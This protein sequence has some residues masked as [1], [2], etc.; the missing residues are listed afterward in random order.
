M[1]LSFIT[2]E[3]LVNKDISAKVLYTRHCNVLLKTKAKKKLSIESLKMSFDSLVCTK[4]V[5]KR[6]HQYVVTSC[7]GHKDETSDKVRRKKK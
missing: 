2:G 7:P 1:C 3:L 5:H 6:C 4:V